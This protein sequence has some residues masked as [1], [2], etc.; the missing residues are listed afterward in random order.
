MIAKDG[1]VFNLLEAQNTE[2]VLPVC[3]AKKE[4]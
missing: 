4:I 1:M 3:I 2:V